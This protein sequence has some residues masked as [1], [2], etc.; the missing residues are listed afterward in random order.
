MNPGEF[1]LFVLLVLIDSRGRG[2]N[3]RVGAF[4][5]A[6]SGR[7]SGGRRRGGRNGTSR[8]RAHS[9]VLFG[10]ATEQPIMSASRRGRLGRR[11]A[12]C[13]RRLHRLILIRVMMMRMLMVIIDG[14]VEQLVSV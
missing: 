12:R 6:I 11:R 2:T 13:R 10:R 5:T 4:E 3:K 1:I 9:A 8:G 7:R 14:V